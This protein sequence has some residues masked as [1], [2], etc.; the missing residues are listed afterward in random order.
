M[1]PICLKSDDYIIVSNINWT[2][3]VLNILAFGGKVTQEK[4]ELLIKH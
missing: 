1:Y 3:K 2:E 4:I